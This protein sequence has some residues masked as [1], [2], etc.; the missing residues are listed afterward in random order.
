M[1]DN[2]EK[3]KPL[4]KRENKN[5]FYYIQIIQRKKDIEWF[6]WNNRPIK[7]YYI[8]SMEQLDRRYE[9][10]KQLC[11]QF[12]ARAYIR[13]SRRNSE[14]IA[15]DMIVAIGESFRNKSYNHLRKI[16]STVVWQSV[17]LDK[18]WIIDIDSW[19]WSI[20][21]Q[22]FIDILTSINPIWEKI[23]AKIP[24]KN[25]LHIITKPFDLHTRKNIPWNW[26]LDVHKNNPTILYIPNQP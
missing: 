12:N 11:K 6:T 18:I 23:I 13:L 25:W 4:L 15:R 26:S 3:I 17:W 1:I 10:I 5:E 19:E 21:W 24:T 7:D 22:Q 16:Y 2:I 9:E 20:I 8:F 14:D